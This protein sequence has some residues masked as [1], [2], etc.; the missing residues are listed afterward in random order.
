[1]TPAQVY[2]K[3]Q[4][5][6]TTINKG[7]RVIAQELEINK[8]VTTYAARHSH[9][10]ILLKSGASLEMIGEN[11]GHTTLKTTQNYIASFDDETKKEMASY[12]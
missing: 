3:I 6:T 9:A 7:M 12:L 1:M 11:L 4:D 10:T 8:K 5:F 2:R